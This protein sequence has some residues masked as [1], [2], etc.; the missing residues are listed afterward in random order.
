[1][2]I[3]WTKSLLLAGMLSLGT[4]AAS[5][6]HG[7]SSFNLS[8][9]VGGFFGGYSYGGGYGYRGCGYGYRGCGY[10][11]YG[12][13]GGW[14]YGAVFYAPPIVYSAPVVYSQPVYVAPPPVVYS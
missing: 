8:I 7:H 10:G 2:T 3:T 9:G 5:M 12:Y 4:P 14:G 11:G 6:A 13:R 1:M